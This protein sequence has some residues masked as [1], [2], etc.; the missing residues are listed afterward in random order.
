MF[1]CSDGRVSG[2]PL[3]GSFRS[4]SVIW[5]YKQFQ[6]EIALGGLMHITVIPE[7]KAVIVDGMGLSFDFPAPENLHALQWRGEKG[8]MEFA[9]RPNRTLAAEEYAEKERRETKVERPLTLE[10]AKAGKLAAVMAA[11]QAAFAPIEAVYPAAER[12][13]W[14]IQEAEARAVLAEPESAPETLAPV[15]SLLVQ[16]RGR[17]EAVADMAAKVLANAGQWRLLYASLTG[18][19]QKMYADVSV[20]STVEAVAAYPTAFHMPEGW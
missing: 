7:D 15:L 8:H 17:G 5:F 19:Q 16:I 4:L 13:G 9:D 14:P 20:L 1:I 12:E 10:E 3:A 18:Q 2:H 11:Y 6:S